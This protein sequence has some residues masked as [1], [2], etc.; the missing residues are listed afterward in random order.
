MAGGYHFLG[1]RD[2]MQL[3]GPILILAKIIKNVMASATEAEVAALYLNA[4]EA[5]AIRQ[6]L[7]KLGHPQPPTPLKTDNVTARGIFKG[8]IEQKRSKAIDMRFY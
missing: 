6:C 5:L 8:T 4:Q 1:N 2:K 7:I 3:N